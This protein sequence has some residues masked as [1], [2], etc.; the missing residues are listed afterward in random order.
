M[1][2]E[3][4]QASGQSSPSVGER[5]LLCRHL[6]GDET[7][8]PELVAMYKKRIYTWLWKHG[9]SGPQAEDLFQ[10]VFLQLHLKAK[11]Y[12]PKRELTP[13]IFTVALN[14]TRDYFR[15]KKDRA[16]VNP[17]KN[18]DVASGERPDASHEAQETASFLA[19]EVLKLPESQR[20]AFLLA[21][22]RDLD[23]ATISSLLDQPIGT[24]KS[25]IHRT[26][27]ALALALQQ[28]TLQLVKEV[29]E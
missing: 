27:L 6:G 29:A 4:S 28:R 13:W 14:V 25:N 22:V 15:S 2:K 1:T 19:A 17:T 16:L 11:I 18:S 7:A 9:L 5:S 24:V 12:D 20:E 3:V 26:R 23:L 10:E 21:T 8:F